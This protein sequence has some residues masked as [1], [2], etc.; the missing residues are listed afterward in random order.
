MEGGLG[1]GGREREKH[2]E[3]GFRK[4]KKG[5]I[6]MVGTALSKDQLTE[7]GFLARTETQGRVG[8]GVESVLGRGERRVTSQRVVYPAYKAPLCLKRVPK[9]PQLLFLYPKKSRRV[10]WRDFSP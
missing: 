8:Q 3:D 10:F 5:L 2:K 7:K 1:E 6:Q 9:P 4:G